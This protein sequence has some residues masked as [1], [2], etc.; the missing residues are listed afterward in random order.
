MTQMIPLKWKISQL[1]P[2][3]KTY[4]WDYN[5]TK[6][7]PI[8]LIECFRKMTIKIVT[9]RLGRTLQ[10][11]KLLQGPNFAGLSGESQLQ[12]LMG[13]WKTRDKIIKHYG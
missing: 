5:L 9:I 13:F 11:E 2:I 1:Y 4:D 12:L 8:L 3:P 7:Q 6:T 10:E